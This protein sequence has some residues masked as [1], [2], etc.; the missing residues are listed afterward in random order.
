MYTFFK[1]INVLLIIYIYNTF[2]NLF[3]FDES[4]HSCVIPHLWGQNAS[5]PT[6]LQFWPGDQELME[7]RED[8]RKT[9]HHPGLEA[10]LMKVKSW[11]CSSSEEE[12][13]A[14]L[15]PSFLLLRS[16]QPL[17]RTPALWFRLHLSLALCARTALPP[18]SICFS[19]YHTLCSLPP[20][21]QGKVHS[22]LLIPSH[23]SFWHPSHLLSP[24]P[25]FKSPLSFGSPYSFVLTRLVGRFPL[26]RLHHFFLDSCWM[27]GICCCLDIKDLRETGW[28]YS[29]FKTLK[30]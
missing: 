30:C 9:Q 29:P 26:F 17:W 5:L 3:L 15:S 21:L 19:P 25:L 10:E 18:P 11:Q 28:S 2:S 22:F 12:H 27:E 14:G 24:P 6:I 13:G 20:E 7:R 16:T 1:I 23:P 4:S 8:K